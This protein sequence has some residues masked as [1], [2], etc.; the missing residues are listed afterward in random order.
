MGTITVPLELMLDTFK[1]PSMKAA[2]RDLMTE[3][4][5]AYYGI[6]TNYLD[7]AANAYSKEILLYSDGR[8]AAFDAFSDFV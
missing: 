2:M 4:G 3:R 8:G 1:L 5:L 7:K 6:L